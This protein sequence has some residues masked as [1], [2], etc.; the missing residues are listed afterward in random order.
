MGTAQRLEAW[1][2]RHQVSVT[3]AVELAVRRY[4][5]AGMSP[6]AGRAGPVTQL[7]RFRLAFDVH[8]ALRARCRELPAGWSQMIEGAAM[9]LVASEGL[10][11][12]W[13]V[14]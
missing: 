8:Q 9:A 1:A 4:L 5:A 11:I 6:A 12:A 13:T 10:P 3:A 14:S 2:E 7:V